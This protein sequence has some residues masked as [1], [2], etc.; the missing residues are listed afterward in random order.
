MPMP[1]PGFCWA[2]VLR[3]CGS[4]FSVSPT[5][6]WP[7]WKNLPPIEVIGT[8][9][10]RFGRRMREPVTVMA[11]LP[12]RLQ[13]LR[14]SRA[15]LQSHATGSAG[16][17]LR[18]FGGFLGERRCRDGKSEAARRKRLERGRAQQILLSH[19]RPLTGKIRPVP[20]RR[21]RGFFKPRSGVRGVFPSGMLH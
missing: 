3:S 4:S 6:V 15:G 7:C 9:D 12:A 16:G 11:C 8:V 20:H 13:S 21:N 19:V 17:G 5:L 1:R 10:S 14:R 2:K 18:L